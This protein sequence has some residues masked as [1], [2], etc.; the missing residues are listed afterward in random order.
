MKEYQKVRSTVKPE[1]KVID[2]FSVWVAANI[3]EV[4]EATG[5]AETGFEGYE[6]DL[7][8][9]DKDEYIELMAKKNALLETQ[10]TDTQLALCEIY[11]GV[12]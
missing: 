4:K 8:Q 11:E 5:D 7:T 6:Y 3:T 10:L 2:E 12:S 9:Y 1:P